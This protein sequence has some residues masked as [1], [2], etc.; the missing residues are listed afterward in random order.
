MQTHLHRSIF[1]ISLYIY[2]P[3]TYIIHT[4]VRIIGFIKIIKHQTFVKK[5]MEL[6]NINNQETDDQ[7]P[8]SVLEG[9][10][11][12]IGR[13]L[14]RESSVGQS[15]RVFYRASEG[16]PFK[17][18]MQPG[19]PKNIIPHHPEE[20]DDDSI[21]PI[22]PSPLMQSLRLPLP[23][24]TVHH[25]HDT[26]EYSAMK[27][28][29]IWSLRKIGKKVETLI[30]SSSSSS[31]NNNNKPPLESS[32]FGEY[33]SS[34]CSDSCSSSSSPSSS[35]SSNS[36]VVDTSAI[37]DGPFCCGPLNVVLDE[38]KKGIY[39]CSKHKKAFAIEDNETI[40]PAAAGVPFQWEVQHGTP[41]TL[42]ENDIISPPP[43]VQRE[44]A[45]EYSTWASRA[46]CFTIRRKNKEK[47][48]TGELFEFDAS[49]R[50]SGSVSSRSSKVDSRVSKIRRNFEGGCF[51]WGGHWKRKDIVVFARRKLYSYIS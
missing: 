26:K 2:F 20:D 35:F 48:K 32:R 21:L 15:S 47:A 10:E 18:E 36:R 4:L 5:Q 23:N 31:N 1:V 9:D 33:S 39:Y 37:D 43:A 27:K 25:D 50:E 38:G 13:I 22:C 8:I 44:E 24:V 3:S 28:S 40:T 49:F 17:W 34:F 19:T 7:N 29:K 11:F 42:P 46:A 14:A 12:C 30:G 41:K 51:S 16:V 6:I 45:E